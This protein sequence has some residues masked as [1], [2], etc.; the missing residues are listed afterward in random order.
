MRLTV[1]YCAI[2]VFGSMTALAQLMEDAVRIANSNGTISSRAAGLGIAYSGIADDYAALYYNPAGLSLLAKKEFSIGLEYLRTSSTATFF[3]V[4]SSIGSSI[5]KPTSC[6]MVFPFK[7]GVGT[8]AIALGYNYESS[9][10]NTLRFDGYNPSSSIVQNLVNETPNLYTNLAYQVS[11]AD[12]IGRGKLHSPIVGNVQQTGF[13]TERGGIHNFTGGGAITVSPSFSVGLSVA[14][15]W[16]SFNYAREYKE[17]DKNN[18]YKVWDKLT[19]EDT[20]F[21]SL[22]LHENISQQIAGVSATVGLQGRFSDAFR[23][24]V[25]IKTPTLY[26]I[27][28]NFSRDISATFDDGNTLVPIYPNNGNSFAGNNSYEIITPFV[29]GLGLSYHIEGLTVS[30]AVEYNDL[31]Q[32]HFDEAQ[33]GLLRLNNDILQKLTEMVT[34]GVGAEYEI[35]TSAVIVRAS[36]MGITSPYLSGVTSTASKI[37]GAGCGIY[38]APNVRLDFAARYSSYSQT[39]SNYGTSGSFVDYTFS[40]LQVSVQLTYRY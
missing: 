14:G 13:I 4:G 34:Y 24:G 16:G 17:A 33:P 10:D 37:F 40:P 18:V 32:L 20:D 19:F 6:G 1:V 12:T 2:V 28:E 9:L 36:Y 8:A 3:G 5:V 39:R 31:S 27:D 29:F 23:F 15:K 11:I 22:T 30:T 21:S 38:V 26:H 25:T 35:P 7:T